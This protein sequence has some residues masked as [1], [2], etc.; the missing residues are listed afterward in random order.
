MGVGGF[1]HLAFKKIKVVLNS[2]KKNFVFRSSHFPPPTDICT[3]KQEDP[4][5]EVGGFHLP[6]CFT[7]GKWQKGQQMQVS[8]AL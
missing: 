7:H 8:G 3:R 2:L 5:D 6:N 4:R 1:S